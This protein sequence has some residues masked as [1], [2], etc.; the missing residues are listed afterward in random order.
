VAVLVTGFF[1]SQAYAYV[2]L[3]LLAIVAA[4]EAR[5][6]ARLG[7]GGK[8]RRAPSLAP[9]VVAPTPGPGTASPGTASPGTA[10]PAAAGPAVR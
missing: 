2:S 4:I 5:F 7:I 1:L 3:V 6:A 9:P 8:V 10:S